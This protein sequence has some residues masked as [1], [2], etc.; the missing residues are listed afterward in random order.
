ML[1]ATR[2]YRFA[3]WA[4]FA[5]VLTTLGVHLISFAPA[6]FEAAARLY[7]NPWY[8][9]RLALVIVH[10]ALVAVTMYAVALAWF[11]RSPGLVGLGLLGYLGFAAAEIARMFLAL[12]WAGA[13]RQR[14]VEST[15]EALRAWLRYTLEQSWPALSGALFAIF[16][17]AFAVGNCCYGLALWRRARAPLDRALGL[18]LLLWAAEGAFVLFGT[19]YPQPWSDAPLEIWSLTFQP[20]VRGVVGVWLLRVSL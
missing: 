18:L 13:L 20:A 3:A 14:Y 6:D 8:N 9:A 5:T 1:A 17:T 11:H 4:A 2:F 10:C 19:F 12:K 16:I 7:Q 15:D